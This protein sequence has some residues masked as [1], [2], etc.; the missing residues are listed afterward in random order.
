MILFQKTN[1]GTLI[2]A[3]DDMD[4]EHDHLVP[5]LEIDLGN[6]RKLGTLERL[7]LVFLD[8]VCGFSFYRPGRR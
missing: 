2:G 5:A 8:D 4:P 1:V 6:V 7:G 3:R